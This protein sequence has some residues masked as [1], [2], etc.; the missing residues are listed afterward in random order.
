MFGDLLGINYDQIFQQVLKDRNVRAHLADFMI[1]CFEECIELEDA[2]V[3][4]F[5]TNKNLESIIDERILAL[6]NKNDKKSR[7]TKI[8]R[9]ENDVNGSI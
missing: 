7:F 6:A 8:L 4:K 3:N 5:K 9:E 1:Y 2:I